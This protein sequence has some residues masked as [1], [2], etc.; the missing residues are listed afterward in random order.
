M[1]PRF[2]SLTVIV[3]LL[4]FGGCGTKR[5]DSKTDESAATPRDRKPGKAERKARK[6]AADEARAKE[7]I[8]KLQTADEPALI[9]ALADQDRRVRRAAVQLLSDKNANSEAV[10]QAML[11][12]LADHWKATRQAARK[13]LARVGEPA[14]APLIAGLAT[15]SPLANLFYPRDKKSRKRINIR[16]MIK[17]T[18]GEMGEVAVPALIEALAHSDGMTRRNAIGALGRMGPKAAAAVPALLAT[19]E[20]DEDAVARTNALADLGQIAPLDPKVEAAARKAA[21]AE[22]A[23]MKDAGTKVLTAIE[24]AKG[25]TG[26]ATP[27]AADKPAPAAAGKPAPAAKQ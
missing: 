2:L 23:R 9:A 10:V 22:D 6:Q 12:L 18:L 3:A 19:H 17:D 26:P 21:A 11:P 27:A 20:K 5:D 4:A 15:D 16:A 1:M 14:V 13:A 7:A 25:E 8:A 24:K